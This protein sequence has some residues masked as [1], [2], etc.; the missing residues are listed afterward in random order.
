MI[1]FERVPASRHVLCKCGNKNIDV[2]GFCDS[3]GEEYAP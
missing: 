1:V 2:H 3:S